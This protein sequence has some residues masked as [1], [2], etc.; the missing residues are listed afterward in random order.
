M[1]KTVWFKKPEEWDIPYI[2]VTDNGTYN[3]DT[4][5]SHYKDTWYTYQIN[6]SVDR[7]Y[8]SFT[9]KAGHNTLGYYAVEP[10]TVYLN[11]QLTDVSSSFQKAYT[12]P[13]P[14]AQKGDAEDTLITDTVYLVC[15][16]GNSIANNIFD[17]LVRIFT[18]HKYTHV[19]LTSNP[20]GEFI[21]YYAARYDGG[22][23]TY[24][25][26]AS[27]VDLYPIHL[28]TGKGINEFYHATKGEYGSFVK[29]INRWDLANTPISHFD[30]MK[31]A[32][33]YW[34]Y[35]DKSEPGWGSVEWTAAALHLGLPHRY[36]IDKL[37]EFANME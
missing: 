30:L 21:T 20:E 23:N 9:D 17:R 1:N 2:L 33:D 35:P 19:G 22:V 28:K 29:D 34:R 26:P 16:K 15:F 6:T 7:Y 24:T 37:I 3:V 32:R 25:E 5:M 31:T 10:T 13:I 18:T 4:K 11:D 36:T 8:I 12:G 27:D 14:P